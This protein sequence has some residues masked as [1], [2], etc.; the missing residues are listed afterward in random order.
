MWGIGYRWHPAYLICVPLVL[1]SLSLLGTRGD[2]LTKSKYDQI[3]LGMNQDDVEDVMG[4]SMAGYSS[5]HG[6][7]S[8]GEDG[9]V[10]LEDGE[11]K[12]ERNGKSITLKFRDGKVASKTQSGL[13]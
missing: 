1:L 5:L 11:M 7:V 10:F 6:S 2:D 8:T 9:D 12:W 3:K 13:K 4:D